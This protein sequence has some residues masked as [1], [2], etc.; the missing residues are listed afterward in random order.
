MAGEVSIKIDEFQTNI[1]NLRSAVSSIE[2][3]IKT[4]EEFE[5]TNIEPFTKDLETTIDAINLLDRYK[6]MLNT[7]IDALENVGDEMVEN[8][9]EIANACEPSA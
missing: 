4:D 8:D 7:D 6:Q 2:S 5:K 1:A 9:E 3:S